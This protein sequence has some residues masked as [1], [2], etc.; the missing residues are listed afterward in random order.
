MLQEAVDALLDNSMVR[1]NRVAN[2]T[3]NR[4]RLKSLSDLLKGKQGRF[5]QNLLGKRVDYSGR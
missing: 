2:S 4:R 1:G 5:R 3:N